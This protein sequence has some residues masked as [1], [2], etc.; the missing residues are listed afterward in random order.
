MQPQIRL[1]FRYFANSKQRCL[2][3]Y[4]ICFVCECCADKVNKNLMKF[5]QLNCATFTNKTNLV[6]SRIH[7]TKKYW[8]YQVFL[9]SYFR[10]QIYSWYFANSIIFASLWNE[11]P[12]DHI[13]LRDEIQTPFCANI[14]FLVKKFRNI[15]LLQL[16]QWD[17]IKF[18]FSA[19]RFWSAITFLLFVW[20]WGWGWG[21]GIFGWVFG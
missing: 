8:A 20:E 2:W 10:G 1:Y 15:S 18:I 6:T 19:C 4:E 14:L 7:Y 16:C 12:L 13:F 21:C 9:E 11:T 17:N 5:S 3:G